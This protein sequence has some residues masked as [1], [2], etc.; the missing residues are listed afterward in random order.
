MQD[1]DQATSLL[2]QAG[3]ENLDVELVTSTA[4]GAGAV[5]SAN[6]F[7]EQARRR[8]VTVQLTKADAN[9]FY[10]DRYLSW[11]FAQDFWN[12]RNYVPQ[13]AT[14]SVK[15][16]TLQRDPLRRPAV[17]RAH[18]PGQARARPGQAQPAAARRAGDRVQHRRLDRLGL[19]A[20]ARRVLEPGAGS[21][22]APLSAVLELRVQARVLRHAPDMNAES[23]EA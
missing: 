6:L 7:V 15:G 2:K 23:G 13:V 8:G 3:Q 10:G 12:T 19:Q 17:H 22:A 9:I 20:P 18:R 21:A 4:V 14:Q 5:E 11:N 16:A 1:I